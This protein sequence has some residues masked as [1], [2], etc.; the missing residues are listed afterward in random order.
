MEVKFEQLF[1]SFRRIRGLA[2][3]LS[4]FRFKVCVPDWHAERFVDFRFDP[5][6]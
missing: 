1:Y 6:E 2:G 3:Y 4:G 5:N